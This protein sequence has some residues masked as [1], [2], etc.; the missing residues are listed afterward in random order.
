MLLIGFKNIAQLLDHFKDRSTCIE[1]LEQQRWPDGKITCIHCG[2]EKVYRTKTG[3]RCAGKGCCKKFSV[4]VD[5]IYENT[6]IPIRLWFGAMY[7]ATAHKKGISS[8]QLGTDLGICQKSAWHMMHRIREAMYD[9]QSETQLK[10]TVQADESYVGGKNRNRH[11]DKQYEHSQGRSVNGKTPVVGL[12]EVNGRVKTFV[13]DNT[14]S[15]TLHQ[16]I[17]EHVDKDA[18]LVTDAYRA[19]SDIGF[20]LQHIVVKH[21]EGSYVTE[22]DGNKFH[23]QN[24][25]NYW[26]VFKRGYM[27]IYHYMSIQGR[28]L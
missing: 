22:K 15:G 1:Y 10:G 2:H 28:I 27:G 12:K 8:I 4:L 23:T 3:F 21:T 5:S 6:K 24:I 20:N 18:V 13:V 11:L 9:A 14:D 25:E 19:Y 16:L 26:S 7:L 17:E